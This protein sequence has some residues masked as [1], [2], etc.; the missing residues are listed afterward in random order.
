MKYTR[1]E[2]NMCLCNRT[3]AAYLDRATGNKM[4]KT[5]CLSY[6]DK[7]KA[8]AKAATERAA[9]YAVT[10][11]GSDPVTTSEMQRV[12][13][14]NKAAAQWEALAKMHHKTRARELRFGT[15]PMV[16]F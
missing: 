14:A 3:Q 11:G 8:E 15:F 2:R 7:A 1:I 6:A 4:D 12:D 16:G 10:F 13:A 5:A 9:L